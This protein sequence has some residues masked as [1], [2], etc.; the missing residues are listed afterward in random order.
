[1]ISENYSTAAAEKAPQ[2]LFVY[3]GGFLTQRRVRR[4][5]ELSGYDISLGKP[6]P[7][8]LIGVWGQSPTSWRGEAVSDKTSAPVLRVEDA[9]LR[10]VLPGRDGEP[11][12]GLHL[13]SRGVHFDPS[14]PSDL[15]IILSQDPLDDAHILNQARDGIAR[16]K[17]LSLSKYNGFDPSIPAP[18][19][20]YVLVIDQ[21]AGDASVTASRADRNTFLEMLFVAREEHPNA[22]I[23]VKTHPETMQGHR[24]G[25]YRDADLSTDVE[26]LS[27]PISPHTLL[28]GAVAVYTVSSQF[29]LEA[30]MAGHRPVV[31]GQPFYMGWGLTDD[32]MPLD[33]RQRKLTR[34]QLFAAAMI[35]Y[36]RWYDPYRDKLCNLSDAIDTLYAQTRAW[37]DDH[38]GWVASGMRLWKRG[39]LQKVFGQHRKILFEDDPDKADKRAANTGRGRMVWAGKSD[40]HDSAMRIEDGFLRSRGLGAELIPPLSLVVDDIGIYYDPTQPSRLETLINQCETLSE[41]DTQR[42]ETLIRQ[43]TKAGLSKYNLDA[44]D[45]PTDVP[46]N[47]RILVPGQVEDDASIRLGTTDI[48]TNLDLLTATRKA[49]PAATI[50]YKPHPDVEAGLRDGAVENADEIAD[51]VLNK[52]ATIAAI[53]AVDEVWTM[54]STTGFEALLRGKDV[55][56][57]GTPFYAGWGLTKDRAAIIPRR[58]ARPTLAQLVHATLIEYPRYFDP[59][60]GQPCP[61]DVVLDRLQNGTI[62]HPS[63]ANRLLAKVQGIFASYAHL[64]R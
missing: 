20:G 64:W 22:R 42:A 3:N 17:K 23:F 29:G 27:S 13:D 12:L 61:V 1:M 55:T 60:T 15:E 63:R 2:R 36:P 47:R 59:V 43:I 51:F 26:F 6:S 39:P 54:T 11:P 38:Q 28:E 62:P 35:I 19:P 49:N 21:T 50:L 58:V 16:L 33:R 9:F 4:I 18:D 8:D 46:T 45:M 32:R 5:L 34:A 31:F 40:G 48:C 41:N 44:A 7:N 57:F 24:D 52:T 25:H 53:D 30:V 14:T 37:R 10:S 56:C